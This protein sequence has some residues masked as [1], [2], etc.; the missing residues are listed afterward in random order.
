ML[1]KK[2]FNEKIQREDTRFSCQTSKY[3]HAVK[4]SRIP[5]EVENDCS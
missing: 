2:E 5:N 1:S 4:I 3:S